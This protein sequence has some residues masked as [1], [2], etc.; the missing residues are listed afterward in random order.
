MIMRGK[1]V[2][3]QASK[4]TAGVL[5]DGAVRMLGDTVEAVGS[6]ADLKRAYPDDEILGDGTQLLMPGL[7]DSHT[8]GAG[9]S[10]LQR[11]VEYDYL[12]KALLDFECSVNLSPE[13]NS[14]LNAV[15]HIRNGCTAIHQNNWTMPLYD[16]EIEDSSRMIEGYRKVGIR[17]AFSPGTRNIN[18]LTYDDE[19]FYKTLPA[20]LQRSAGYLLNFDKKA[21]VRYYLDCFEELYSRFNGADVRIIYGP[22]WVQGSTDDFLQAVEEGAQKHG[23]L[24]IHIHTLQTPVQKAYGKRRYGK[25]LVQHMDDL[26]L[27]RDNLVLGHAVYL[28][29]EDI[30]LLGSR[31]ASVTHH[32]S[33]NLATR[34][35]IAPV[36]EMVRQGVNVCMGI[37]EKGINDDEDMFMEMRMCWFLHRIPSH[38]LETPALSAFTVLQMATENAA[39]VTGYPGEIGMLAPGKRA[40]A[41]LVDLK[42]VLQDP[43]V[44]PEAKL[45]NVV[46]HRAL[47]RY[48]DT[49]VIGGRKVMEDRVFKTVD[50]EALYKEARAQIAK[51]RTPEQETYRTLLQRIR[52]YYIKWYQTI[53]KDQKIEPFY[54][55]NSCL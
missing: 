40:D 29:Q 42:P 9:M 1:Y 43:C 17:T 47:G 33:C 39:R 21:A 23:G 22:N 24:P 36:Y 32:P 18:I 44:S 20:D 15:R 13:L 6:F 51:G 49:V 52:P 25:T 14:Q 50:V 27:V 7:I 30:E 31:S 10:Y 41:I 26:G 5:E 12:E 48:V 19:D 38:S 53:L 45:E 11:G 16:R 34:N 37:D 8:H 35:G 4:G 3:T 2:L 28:D 54:P 46:M 55:M